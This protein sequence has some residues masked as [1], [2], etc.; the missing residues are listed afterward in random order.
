MKNNN[1]ILDEKTLY[2]RD[3]CNNSVV[4]KNNVNS[5]YFSNTSRKTINAGILASGSSR[6]LNGLTIYG[7]IGEKSFNFITPQQYNRYINNGIEPNSKIKQYYVTQSLR[8]SL[9]TLR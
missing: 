3:K 7:N 4:A 9:L 2:C 8:L 1:N 5:P 6:L